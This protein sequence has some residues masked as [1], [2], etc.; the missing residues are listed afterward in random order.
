MTT[1]ISG[2]AQ[3]CSSGPIQGSGF[4]TRNVDSELGLPCFLDLPDTVFQPMKQATGV[5][6][7]TVTGKLDKNPSHSRWFSW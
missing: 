1:G 5:P 4:F 7:E 6:S 2:T 3:L